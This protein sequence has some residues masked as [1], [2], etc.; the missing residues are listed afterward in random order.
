MGKLL[1]FSCIYV[2]PSFLIFSKKSINVNAFLAFIECDNIVPQNTEKKKRVI[3]ECFSVNDF[4]GK[5]LTKYRVLNT[6][7]DMKGETRALGD[8]K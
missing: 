4:E 1:I 3:W 7:H 8:S 6:H 2:Q 5:G